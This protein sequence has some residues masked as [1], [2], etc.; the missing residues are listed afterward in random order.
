MAKKSS[1]SVVETEPV[2]ST[3]IA[4]TPPAPQEKAPI[5]A[6]LLSSTAPL[7][8]ED[9]PYD[10][11]KL[12]L[13]QAFLE[14]TKVKK[15][16]TVV[17]VGRPASQ[18]F[19]RIHPAPGYR[20]SLAFLEL[21]EERETYLVDLR[22]VPELAS[23]CYGATLFTGMTRAGVLFQWPV[24]IPANDGRVLEWY[25]SA[26]EAAEYAMTCWIRIK[27]NMELKAYEIFEAEDKG[28][29]IPDPV[30]PNLTYGQ[31]YRIAFNKGRLIHTPDHP[32]IKRLR[33]G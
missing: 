29:N 13:P 8:S 21:K 16:L 7:E 6:S 28:K 2:P 24:R 26:A 4:E 18:S 23:E 31:I 32:A 22:K 19:F 14:T 1:L 20:E 30:W 9:D 33:G 25:A 27:A 5:K 10:L 11:E 17:P 12:R 3:P 15:L